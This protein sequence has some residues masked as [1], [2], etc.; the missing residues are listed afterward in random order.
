MPGTMAGLPMHNALNPQELLYAQRLQ[1]RGLLLREIAAELDVSFQAVCLGLYG[2]NESTAARKDVQRA[3]VSGVVEGAE[4][5]T[6]GSVAGTQVPPV[7]TIIER[8]VPVTVAAAGASPALLSRAAAQAANANKEDEDVALPPAHAPEQPGSDQC[9]V[10]TPDESGADSS[11]IHQPEAALLPQTGVVEALVAHSEP[12][13][14]DPA[15]AMTSGAATRKDAGTAAPDDPDAAIEAERLELSR[16][17]HPAQRF[18]LVSDDGQTLHQSL[19]VLTR[20]PS[21]FW[22][23]TGEQLAA[24]R[25]RRPQ[26]A[27]LKPVAV[28]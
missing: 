8:E 19:H 6:A 20:L 2:G 5:A 15:D 10:S 22:R 9:S 24:V 21:F 26:W 13:V 16:S 27:H 3:E 23:G 17:Y 28:T 7:D 25:R 1:R 4:V 14:Y 12:L 18:R 11:Q